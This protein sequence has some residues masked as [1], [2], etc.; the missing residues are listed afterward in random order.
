MGV[1]YRAFKKDLHFIFFLLA[2]EFLFDAL[3]LLSFQILIN[4]IW[5]K[6]DG[7]NLQLPWVVVALGASLT[8]RT[9]LEGRI[10]MLASALVMSVRGGMSMIVMEKILNM[11]GVMANRQNVGQICNML[12]SDFTILI[13]I[14]YN[15]FF[16]LTFVFKLI[17]ILGILYYRL[18]WVGLFLVV[19]TVL[20][21]LYQVG[22]SKIFEGFTRDVK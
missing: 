1:I 18:G 2:L 4:V 9:A 7:W 12:V 10:S 22:V 13:K 17:V 21:F 6:S 16:S 20:I 5:E 19:P 8:L 3:N 11:T 15:F 14:P